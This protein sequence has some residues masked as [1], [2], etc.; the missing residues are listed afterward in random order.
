MQAVYKDRF[1]RVLRKAWREMAAY[2]RRP[3]LIF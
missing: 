3:L 1:L 2:K